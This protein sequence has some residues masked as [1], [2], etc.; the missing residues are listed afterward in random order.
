MRSG[1]TFGV[2][3]LPDWGEIELFARAVKDSTGLIEMNAILH[4]EFG[5]NNGHLL[6][7]QTGTLCDS[8]NNRK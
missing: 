3:A 7:P 2:K 6:S 8:V 1:E 4:K 5:M